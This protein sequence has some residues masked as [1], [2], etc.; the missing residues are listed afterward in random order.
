MRPPQITMSV[1]D[2]KR[3]D[4]AFI[5]YMLE[6]YGGDFN[7]TVHIVNL[8]FFGASGKFLSAQASY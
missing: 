3:E 4:V 1:L 7:A 5:L 2:V 8:Y 6:F